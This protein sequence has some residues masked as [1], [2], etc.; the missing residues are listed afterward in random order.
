M[1]ILT[2]AIRRI[3]TSGSNPTH[4]RSA[5]ADSGNRWTSRALTGHT[6]DDAAALSLTA[7]YRGVSLIAAACAGQ[8]IHVYEDPRDGGE[9]REIRTPDTAYLWLEPN[10]EQPKITLWERVFAD[11]VRGNAFLWVD[12]DRETS[13]PVGL[14]HLSR[15]RVQVGRASDGRKVYLVDGQH[16]MIDYRQGG[17]IVHIPNWGDSIVGYDI[18]K[19]AAQSIALGLSAEEFAAR[20]FGEGA[21]PPGIITTPQTLT[22]KQSDAIAK[23]WGARHGGVGKAQLFGVFSNGATFEKINRDLEQM[24]LLPIREFQVADIAR[25][26]G[27]APHLLG[28]VNRSTSW[29]AGIAEQG[30]ATVTYTLNAHTTRVKQAVDASLLVR[31]LTGRFMEFDPGGFLRG[32]ILQQGQAHALAYGRWMTP[33]EIRRDYN[34]PPKDGGDELLAPVNMAPLDALESME[35]EAATAAKAPPDMPAE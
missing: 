33:N 22:P 30:Q 17:E 9:R 6:V 1:T 11:E 28:D 8:P 5:W 35:M 32:S 19:L 25:L 13:R 4:K 21:V 12:K 3:R 29:G 10:D 34:L 27:L 16:A 14:W 31:E 20:E 23:N 7:F 15:H 24:Q 18:V 2:G 26:L